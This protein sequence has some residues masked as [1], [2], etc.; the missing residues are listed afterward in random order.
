MSPRKTLSWLTGTQVAILG[1]YCLLVAAVS[2]E[3]PLVVGLT[4]YFGVKDSDMGRLMALQFGLST[5]VGLLSGYLS[6]RYNRPRLWA[7]GF[8]LVTLS[9][10]GIALGLN[11]RLSFETYFLLKLIAGLGLGMV[12]PLPFIMLMDAAPFEKRNRMFGL[13]MVMGAI[14]G[15]I[16]QSL[17]SV[18]LY[19]KLGLAGSYLVLAGLMLS[20]TLSMAITRDPKRGAQDDALKDLL[21]DERTAYNYHVRLSDIKVVAGKPVNL[22]IATYNALALVPIQF[23]SFWIITYLVR[24]Y[25]MQEVLASTIFLLAFAGTPVGNAI[26]GVL[27]DRPKFRTEQGRLKIAI[28]GA[29]LALP[30]LLISFGLSWPWTLLVVFLF[31]GNTCMT[32]AQP[33]FTSLGQEVNLPEHRGV[34]T[35]LNGI[36]GGIANMGCFWGPPVIAELLGGDYAKAFLLCALVY[37]PV[38]ALLLV[39]RGR[40]REDVAGVNTVLLTRADQVRA[41]LVPSPAWEEV[42][43]GEKYG[44]DEDDAPDNRHAGS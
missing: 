22:L 12:G 13:L 32:I 40:I 18:C 28:L 39:I 44:Y 17:P 9:S 7:L 35:A 27:A 26:G 23:I 4:K 15:G 37:L 10:A 2:Y 42:S 36:L 24:S 34:W 20:S 31:L 41:A 14:G 16:G 8:L 6:D 5:L 1:G 43:A 29:V 19:L 21:Q 25:G 3:T 11:A 33:A 38:L 30:F